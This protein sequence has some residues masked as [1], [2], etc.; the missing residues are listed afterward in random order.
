MSLL[1]RTTS[2]RHLPP[3]PTHKNAPPPPAYS[4][5]PD[6]EA[7]LLVPPPAYAPLSPPPPDSAVPLRPISSLSFHSSLSTFSTPDLAI[8]PHA[9]K[10]IRKRGRVW[11]GLLLIV[12]VLARAVF[13]LVFVG[14]LAGSPIW[15][16]FTLKGRAR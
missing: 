8:P 15:L 11:R 4:A 7:G 5:A 12:N 3:H 1:S 13:W 16:P 2:P 14:V 6:L 9:Q 10:D